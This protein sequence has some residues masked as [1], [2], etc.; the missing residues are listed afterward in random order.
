RGRPV[1]GGRCVQ[2]SFNMPGMRRWF[3]AGAVA[4]LV[5]GMISIHAI[6]NRI[7]PPSSQVNSPATAIPPLT[8]G[9]YLA[10]FPLSVTGDEKS[11]RYVA[12][13]LVDALS[14]KMFQLQELHLA[15]S[16]AVEKVAAKNQPVSDA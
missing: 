7:V 4:P 5:V 1:V 16:S 8:Q 13:G 3:W 11:L 10:V 2:H 6:R 12:D 14:A 9:K 15:S